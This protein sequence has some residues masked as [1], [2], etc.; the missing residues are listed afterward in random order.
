MVIAQQLREYAGL[1]EEQ[2]EDNFRPR[3]YRRASDVVAALNRPIATILAEGGREALVALPA[4]G[5][6]IAGAII[7]MVG[8]GRWGQLERL[9]GE[10]APEVLFRTIPGIGPRL[11]GVLAEE[12]TLETL[13]DLENAIHFGNF[14]LKGIGPRRKQMIASALA[15]RLARRSTPY[16]W[17][18][19]SQ[20]P[21]ALL[22]KVDRA[23]RDKAAAG[24]LR[25]IAPRRF[26]PTHEAWLPVMHSKVEDWHFTVLFSNSRRAHE[27]G[28]TKDWVVIYHQ[29]DDEPEGRSIVTTST[30][31]STEGKRVVRRDLLQRNAEPTEPIAPA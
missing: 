3:A 24:A 5:E 18:K 8:S 15:E 26:N 25:L 22:L 14:A 28:K 10:L 6:A 9:R 31:G 13:E 11:A 16:L 1:L 30:H 21:V 7:E 17:K 19:S 20:P 23:Y 29:R 12:G 2:G 4:V 27:L